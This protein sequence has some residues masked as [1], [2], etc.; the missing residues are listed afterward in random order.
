MFFKITLIRV[1]A[2]L[3]SASSYPTQ[4][5]LAGV[6]HL[7]VSFCMFAAIFVFSSNWPNTLLAI[8]QICQV[9]CQII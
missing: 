8:W 3:V 6:S 1:D 2:P 5:I 7:I 9:I 4:C